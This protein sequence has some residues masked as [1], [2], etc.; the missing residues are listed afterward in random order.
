MSNLLT[1][2]V[3]MLTETQVK[4]GLLGDEWY[5]GYFLVVVVAVAV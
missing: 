5:V 1:K 2:K 4:T 3:A